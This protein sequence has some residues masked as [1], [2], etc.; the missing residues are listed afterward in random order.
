MPPE[1]S[2]PS[3]V[4]PHDVRDAPCLIIHSNVLVAEDLRDILVSVGAPDVVTAI[5][6]DQAPLRPARL[7]MV[8][9]SLEMIKASAQASYWTEQAIPVV[10]LDSERQNDEAVQAG[11]HPLDEPFRTEDVTELLAKLKVF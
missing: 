6:L 10:L 5:S 8:S 7:V 3:G 1:L 4:T 11:F 9:G 2:R